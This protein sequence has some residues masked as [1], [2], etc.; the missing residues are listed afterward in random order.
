VPPPRAFAVHGRAVFFDVDAEIVLGAAQGAWGNPICLGRLDAVLRVDWSVAQERLE[1]ALEPLMRS[2]LGCPM[3]AIAAPLRRPAQTVR[4]A[5]DRFLFLP[6][7]GAG[8]RKPV[9]GSTRAA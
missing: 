8:P 3:S 6:R 2:R 7:A 4:Q 5:N 1:K 9:G